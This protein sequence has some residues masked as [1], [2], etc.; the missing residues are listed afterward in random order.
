MKSGNPVTSSSAMFQ[1][2]L[3]VVECADGTLYTGY[4]T[5]VTA[6]VAT[7]NAGKGAKCTRA[8]LPVRLRAQARFYTKPRALSAEARFKQLDRARKDDLLARAASQP[9]L[10]VLEE[11]LPGL[12]EE[13]VSEF[14]A[15]ELCQ[16]QDQGYGDFAR[17]LLPSVDPRRVVGVR[18]PDLRKIARRLAKRPDVE[19]FLG[20]VPHTL[21]E[22]DQ[23]HSFVIGTF[24][25]YD[26]VLEELQR[27][28]PV[29]DN[30]AT[31]DQLPTKALM[32]QPERTLEE[33][34]RWIRSDHVYTSRFGMEVLMRHFLDDLFQPC[35]L[36]MVVQRREGAERPEP[37][38]PA[39]YLHM[40]R[41]WFFAECAAKQPR[42]V[43]PY[44]LHPLGDG[45][46]ALD[47]WTR[48]K[49]IQKSVESRRV[50]PELKARL[51]AARKPPR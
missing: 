9:F 48:L 47:E 38:T 46:G 2:Y 37:V 23:L 42:A 1:H 44:L 26:R 6:R 43:L 17:K 33:M 5:D 3:Y 41:A 11:H 27:F 35:F 31:C 7:H 28:L 14:V 18:T 16:A 8:R 51:K 4:T 49:A 34:A 20:D 32:Q 22:E 15:R 36:D 30:W 29:V 45:N 12:G 24:K 10:Q 13:P 25:E 19:E 40:M 50:D 21:F 39:Y